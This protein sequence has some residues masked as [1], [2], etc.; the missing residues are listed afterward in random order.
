MNRA[1]HLPVWPWKSPV[2]SLSFSS[3]TWPPSPEVSTLPP[4]SNTCESKMVWSH[5]QGGKDVLHAPDAGNH[6]PRFVQRNPLLS[7]L[8]SIWTWYILFSPKAVRNPRLEQKK[9]RFIVRIL[10]S[11]SLLSFKILIDHL[12][13]I[14]SGFF[15]LT[16]NTGSPATPLKSLRKN[17]PVCFA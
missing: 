8:D 3:F 5:S 14:Q 6:G 10:F 15:V 16:L 17:A 11:H 7:S 12:H 9:S 4:D 1:P 13:V 2:P